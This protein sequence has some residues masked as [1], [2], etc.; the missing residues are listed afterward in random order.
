MKDLWLYYPDIPAV[1]DAYLALSDTL[2]NLAPKA[3]EVAELKEKKLTHDDLMLEAIK[4][5]VQ[6]LTLYPE[7]PTADDAALNLVNAYLKLGD[8]KSTIQLCRALRERFPESRFLDSFEYVEALA[9]WNLSQYDEA[10]GVA[11]KVAETIYKLPDG[12]EKPSDN[13]DLALYIIGQI[14]HA[15]GVPAKAIEYYEKV[16]GMFADAAEAIA[17]FEQKGLALEEVSTFEPGQQVEVTLKYRNIPEAHVLVYRVDLMTLYLTE[18]N[19]SRIARVKLAGIHPA[20]EPLRVELGEGKDYAEKQKVLPL[21]LKDSGA[22][23]VICRGGDLYASGMVLVTPL[24]LE[25]QE[26]KVSGRVRVNV[27]DEKTGAYQKNVHVKVIGS[28]N[29]DFMS[30]QTDLRGVFIADGVRGTATVI[31]RGEDGQFAFYRGK[32]ALG[33]PPERAGGQPAVPGVTKG[34]SYLSNVDEANRK[35]QQGRLSGQQGLFQQKQAG[36][37]VEQMMQQ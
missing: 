10:T 25:V 5:L 7:N 12:T 29:P 14:W 4:V 18:K 23:L 1:T 17:Y 21:P 32:E 3:G 9:L 13:K 31:A 26:D 6:Y 37:Q 19:L 27:M 28:A 35:L 34:V 20:M 24:K 15:R 2:Y 22:Y 33:K 11:A 36:V 8:F 16:K 30:G